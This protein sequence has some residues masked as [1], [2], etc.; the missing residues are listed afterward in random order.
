[1]TLNDLTRG[2][3]W[4]TPDER[5]I[6]AEFADAFRQRFAERQIP[7]DFLLAE[8]VRDYILHRVLSIRLENNLILNPGGSGKDG[9]P[10]TH[11]VV[12]PV[13]A[14]HIVRVR[15]RVRKSLMD[16]ED[17]ARE[18]DPACAAADA[19]GKGRRGGKNRFSTGATDS[20]D[21]K[22]FNPMCD[23]KYV[24]SLIDDV[25]VDL[26]DEELFS[27]DDGPN[28]YDL[29]VEEQFRLR[30]HSFPPHI[31]KRIGLPLTDPDPI[32]S[33]A[34]DAGT[35]PDTAQSANPGAGMPHNTALRAAP[36][37]GTVPDEEDADP[38]A[39]DT[40]PTERETPPSTPPA[41]VLN[42]DR[43]QSSQLSQPSHNTQ[44]PT[45]DSDTCA[46]L[47]TVNYPQSTPPSPTNPNPDPDSVP[48]LSI[49]NC[50][51]S[52]PR[53]PP[54]KVEYY[55]VKPTPFNQRFKYEYPPP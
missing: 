17:A 16:V 22:P 14:G 33:A 3:H 21:A 1:M 30:P 5:Q 15:D 26:N 40:P 47:S 52:I 7:E 29:P 36:D 18:R 19:R 41:E 37:T 34:P 32:Q 27:D 4:M 44:P 31:R 53:T 54:P 42:A 8:R 49:I 55:R 43:S 23:P 39:P 24:Q 9:D 6:A 25:G 12:A 20:S 46:S 48:S 38:P 35:A 28:F 2:E 51:L 50:P 11:P 13:L 10:G 45:P